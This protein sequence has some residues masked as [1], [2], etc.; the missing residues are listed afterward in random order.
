MSSNFNFYVNR[1]GVQG[2]RGAKGE[3]GFSPVISVESQTANEYILKVENEDG[4]FTTPN[5]R[6]NAIEN[7]GG[8]YIRF[9]PDTAQMY[10]GYADGATTEQAGVVRMG[11]YDDLVAGESEELV[12]NVADVHNYVQNNIGTSGFVTTEQFNTY[13]SETA[14]TLDN[15]ENNKLN[16]STFDSYTSATNSTL[17]SLST[18]KVNVSD[19]TTF[20]NNTNSA[21]SDLSTNKLNTSAF[22]SYV[23][24]TSS[25]LN[26][27]ESEKL[28]FTDLSNSLIE[29]VNVTLTKDTE[30]KTI[31]ISSSGSAQVQANWTETDSSNPSFIQNKPTLGTMAS[32]DASDYTPS[33]GLS[34]VAISG[35][36]ND[37]LNKPTIPEAQV[38]ADWNATSGVSQILNKPTLFSGDY[39]DLTNKPDIPAAANNAT[40]TITQGGVTKGSFTTDQATDGTIDIDAVSS[41]LSAGNGIDINTSDEIDIMQEDNIISATY[42]W[43]FNVVG[44]LTEVDGVYSGFS[45]Y[46]NYLKSKTAFTVDIA[47]SLDIKIEFTTGAD[48][49]A[50]QNLLNTGFSTSMVVSF[51]HNIMEIDYYTSSTSRESEIALYNLSIRP[52]TTY[53]LLINYLNGELS[54][55]LTASGA[56]PVTA[57]KSGVSGIYLGSDNRYFCIGMKRNSGNA[58]FGGS[59]NTNNSYIKIDGNFLDMTE[60]PSK[61][62][63]CA[64]ATSSLYGLVKPDNDTIT[65]NNGVI[66]VDQSAL[67]SKQDALV[68][69]TNIKTINGDS[70]LGSGDITTG[71]VSSSTVNNIV[72]ITQADYDALATKDANT[73]YIITDAPAL[74]LADLSNISEEGINLIKNNSS[75]RNAGELISTLIPLQDAN[76][77]LLDGALLQYGTYKEF[78]DYIATLYGDGTS[79]PSY[80]CTES[81]WQS[82]V[83]QYGVCGKFVYD[84]TNNTVRLPKVTGKIDG[85]TD[86]N[87]LGDLEPLFVR[88]PNTTGSF[89]STC[90]NTYTSSSGAFSTVS[91]GSYTRGMGDYTVYWAQRTF[92]AS[93]SSS[94]YSGNGSDTAIHEQAIKCFIYIVIAT[95]SKT[96]IQTNIDEITTD[97]NGKADVDLSNMSASQSVK[98]EIISWGMPDYSAS[99]SVTMP[100]TAPSNGWFAASNSNTT[101]TVII[102]GVQV[103]QGNWQNGAWSGN[104]NCQ[105]MVAKGD[106]ITGATGTMNFIPCKGVK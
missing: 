2:E 30:N 43:D 12:P 61:S 44:N 35:S 20:A 49:R 66:E 25:T 90:D 11:T 60:N 14:I 27:L 91:T 73:Q 32:E 72:Q 56:T 63:Y 5:L 69:G 6:G 13:T 102:N 89:Y 103:A 101:T 97:L 106:V 39:N 75:G 24:S 85:T 22:D 78:I 47:T 62:K 105:I 92:D 57:T 81:E 80:F 40:I 53:T 28:D 18:N 96:E 42:N 46:S 7:N 74:A 52:N 51:I 77:H 54:V 87:A 79:I 16:K 71:N 48:V 94:V 4:S 64:K 15:L 33:A 65:V 26:T 98:N 55:S 76:L 41:S 59:I 9:N 21:L 38:N 31:T 95:S 36:Y 83:T 84:N 23:N 82:S 100:Y 45:G 50:W 10:T 88:L 67:T 68:S 17:E 86:L 1:Q 29:G 104:L 8:T 99:V 37:L 93:K 58:D 34:D 70:I 19:Y 3:Q